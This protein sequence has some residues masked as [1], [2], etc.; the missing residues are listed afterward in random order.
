[1]LS[2]TDSEGV[3]INPSDESDAEV[4]P[5]QSEHHGD[6]DNSDSEREES[7]SENHGDNDGSDPGLNLSSDSVQM[8]CHLIVPLNRSAEQCTAL[9]QTPVNE[10]LEVLAS[11]SDEITSTDPT[12]GI[13][14]L[15]KKTGYPRSIRKTG[16]HC[17]DAQLLVPSF[18][19]QPV[20]ESLNG[21]SAHLECSPRADTIISNDQSPR[22]C[23]QSDWHRVKAGDQSFASS[24]IETIPPTA[25]ERPKRTRQLYPSYH[26]TG[27]LSNALLSAKPQ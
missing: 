1:M 20:D 12:Q 3:D 9:S 6:S 16:R 22:F 5:S 15:T 25:D 4:S 27:A 19:Q 21:P 11:E 8:Y 17:R 2:T 18:K 13:V 14:L 10:W 26:S 24:P 7:P 23:A